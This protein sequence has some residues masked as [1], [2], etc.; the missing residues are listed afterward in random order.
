MC[1]T[2]SY[3]PVLFANKHGLYVI[4]T[5]SEL[6]DVSNVTVCEKIERGVRRPEWINV[7]KDTFGR[8]RV[9]VWT[10]PNVFAVWTQICPEPHMI[11]KPL[12][13]TSSDLLKFHSESKVVLLFSLMIQHNINTHHH[14]AAEVRSYHEGWHIQ[15]AAPM[16]RHYL[17]YSTGCNTKMKN[18]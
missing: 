16:P 1:V 11:D 7:A 10:H 6:T 5:Q 9:Q 18:W 3:F 14:R 17:E 8:R 15:E 12:N 13:Y 2:G 4:F